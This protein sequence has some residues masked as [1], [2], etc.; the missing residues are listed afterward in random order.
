MFYEIIINRESGS[1]IFREAENVAKL[2][3]IFSEAGHDTK[4]TV[5][6]PE[7]LEN[8][9]KVAASSDSGAIIIGGGD[10]SVT[11]AARFLKDTG[12]PLGVLP[13]GTFNL[14]ARDLN[15]PLDPFAAAEKLVDADIVDIDLLSVGNELCLCA[16]VIGFYPALA[17]SREDFHGKSWWKKTIRVIH[18]VATVAIKS[19]ALELETSGHKEVIQ[20]K[21]RLAAFSPG[22][23]EE[24]IGTLPAREDLSSGLLTAYV[25]AHLSRSQMLKAA[26]K[27]MTGTLLETEKMIQAEAEKIIIKVGS[28]R[29]IPAMIDGEIIQIKLPCELRILPKALRVLRPKKT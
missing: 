17:K 27:F 10:G 8:V 14:E 20:Q 24:N 3:G 26:F 19:P 28:K 5:V 25:S 4:V 11:T 7:E 2:E 18:E 9:L 29:T 22:S 23:Y 12:K 6:A 21:T 13:L 1:G 15:I 16:M